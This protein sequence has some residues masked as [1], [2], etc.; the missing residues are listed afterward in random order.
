MISIVEIIQCPLGFPVSMILLALCYKWVLSPLNGT[1]H[2]ISM[3]FIIMPACVTLH[4]LSTLSAA[5]QIHFKGTA[6][7]LVPASP[8][9]ADVEGAATTPSSLPDNANGA[10]ESPENRPQSL[11]ALGALQ[12]TVHQLRR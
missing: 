7:A 12:L 9:L 8:L 6:L 1:R 5:L 4:F 11:R 10:A 2:T 3:L